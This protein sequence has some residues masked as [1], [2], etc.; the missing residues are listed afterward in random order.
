[1]IT[2]ITTMRTNPL[3]RMQSLTLSDRIP[4]LTRSKANRFKM[5]A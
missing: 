3:P 1:M 2:P 5:G 4:T